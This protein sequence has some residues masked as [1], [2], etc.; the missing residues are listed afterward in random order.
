M[1]RNQKTHTLVQLSL[2]TAIIL[3][4]AFTPVGYLKIG[5]LSISFLMIP[6]VIG[7]MILGPKAGAFL[8]GVFGLTSFFQCFGM[9]WFGTTLMGVNPI[10]TFITCVVARVLAGLLPGL[11]F[12]W[13]EK[14][15][16]TKILS[17]AITSLSGALLN[18]FFFV[19]FLVIFFSRTLM[20]MQMGDTV[21]AVITSLVTINAVAEAIVCLVVG[22]A[23]AKAV[24]TYNGNR[25]NG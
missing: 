19:G 22:A 18:T 8:G 12:S 1:N 6:V 10:A 13:M 23:I 3:V 17:Y 14:I 24:S 16:K 20:E 25:L 21:W 2:L 5:A 7:G 9:D 4:M 15:D 11:L